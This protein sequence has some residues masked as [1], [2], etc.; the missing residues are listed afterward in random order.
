MTQTQTLNQNKPQ[1]PSFPE[2]F[3]AEFIFDFRYGN[4]PEINVE[5]VKKALDNLLREYMGGDTKITFSRN[6]RGIFTDGLGTKW[7]VGETEIRTRTS[8]VVIK[9]ISYPDEDSKEAKLLDKIYDLIED[10][11]YKVQELLEQK[12]IEMISKEAD[13]PKEVVEDQGWFDDDLSFYNFE[14]ERTKTRYSVGISDG[15]YNK[16]CGFEYSGA[17]YVALNEMVLHKEPIEDP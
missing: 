1:A 10:L 17:E 7:D 3:S 16:G 12:A 4:K 9:R 5:E 15:W 14:D 6:W 2:G 11:E 13:I 8:K